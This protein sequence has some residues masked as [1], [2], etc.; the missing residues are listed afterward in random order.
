MLPARPHHIQFLEE[1]VEN[2][3]GLVPADKGF[4]DAVRHALLQERLG[5]IVITPAR[6]NMPETIPFPLRRLCQRWRKRIVLSFF[7]F[8][9]NLCFFGLIVSVCNQTL[10]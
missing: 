1:L 4:I 6:K 7:I 10:I 8:G 3:T 2:F 5:I 9:E